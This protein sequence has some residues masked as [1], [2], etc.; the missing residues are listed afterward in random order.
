MFFSFSPELA[1]T[2]VPGAQRGTSIASVMDGLVTLTIRAVPMSNNLTEF[3]KSHLDSIKRLVEGREDPEAFG[4]LA[5]QEQLGSQQLWTRLEELM[6][7]EGPQ[8]AKA[9]R[10]LRAF[11]PR[12]CGP[13][14]LF[15]LSGSGHKPFVFF[16]LI[17]L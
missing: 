6:S 10:N 14:L 2:K 11:G 7:K 8:W 12:G 13:N 1:P 4:Q 15:D 9:A 3:L 17:L 16:E 5:K